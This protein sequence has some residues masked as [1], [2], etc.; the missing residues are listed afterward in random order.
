MISYMVKLLI[1]VHVFHLSKK[2]YK[3]A[4]SEFS[5]KLPP[6]LVGPIYICVSSGFEDILG[7]ALS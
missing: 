7:L 1:F 5:L 2:T 6:F 4:Y 3:H